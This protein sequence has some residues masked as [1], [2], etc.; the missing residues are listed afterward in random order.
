MKIY[1]YLF[2][3]KEA[4]HFFHIPVEMLHESSLASSWQQEQ[5]VCHRSLCSFVTD[6]E[7][8]KLD[9]LASQ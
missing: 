5:L 7:M 8:N 9:F 1:F 4:L 6:E 2:C 3:N